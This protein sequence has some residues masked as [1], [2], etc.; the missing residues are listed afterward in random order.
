MW[1]GTNGHSNSSLGGSR[2]GAVDLF[3]A[4]RNTTDP[5]QLYSMGMQYHRNG[6]GDIG[7]C[8]SGCDPNVPQSTFRGILRNL[9]NWF[10][11]TDFSNWYNTTGGTI[12]GGSGP[13]TRAHDFTCSKC[14]TP[15]AS[16]LP[17][18]LIHNCLDQSAADWSNGNLNPLRFQS[19]NCHRKTTTGDG[20]HVLAPGQ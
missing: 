6:S 15:H 20:W 19:T 13:G 14:H 5:D 16:G 3:N 7:V 9:S 18:L 1:Q 2:T 17:A 4:H 11:E 8:Y 12:G 10:D